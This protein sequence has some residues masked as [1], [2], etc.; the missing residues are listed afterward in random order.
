[1]LQGVDPTFAGIHGPTMMAQS[2]LA[3][4]RGRPNLGPDAAR[5]EGRAGEGERDAP[6]LQIHSGAVFYT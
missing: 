3:A 4:P 2:L 5:C 1:V 6:R